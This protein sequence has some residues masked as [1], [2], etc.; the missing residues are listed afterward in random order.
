MRLDRVPGVAALMRLPGPVPEVVTRS[1]VARAVRRIGFGDPAKVDER[2]VRS[3]TL[4]NRNRRWAFHRIAAAQ[5]CAPEIERPFR[6]E[7]VR[8]PAAV[9]W[10]TRDVLCLI[11]G[12]EP[13]AAT[14]GAK[15]I[16]VEGCGHLPQVEAPQSILEAIDAPRSHRHPPRLLT[17]IDFH[18]AAPAEIYDAVAEMDGDDFEELMQDPESRERVI[19][20]M[21]EHMV[22]LFR[23]EKAKGVDAVIHI[24][25]WDK[26]GGG[27]EHF[28]MVIADGECKLAKR[29]RNEPDLTLKVR[30]TDLRKL[31]TGETGA[32][33]LA[34]KGR[35]RAIGDIGLGHEDAGPVPLL[36]P[37]DHAG[38]H[39]ERPS[40]LPIGAAEGRSTLGTGAWS[41]GIRRRAAPSSDSLAASARATSSRLPPT[42]PP[43]SCR[44]GPA[45]RPGGAAGRDAAP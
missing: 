14:L 35:L 11:E 43:F 39:G 19:E 18:T 36:A 41:Q 31:V 17:T 22:G 20:A 21:I 40:H 45:A 4:H 6:P 37:R 25:L 15:L 44:R 13:L 16:V 23:P 8:V 30:P 3:F 28:E 29:P 7:L 24:K 34:L 1:V 2:F 38:A 10:G 32:R 26:P 42:G 27:Y 9:V 5:T 12:A 33:R